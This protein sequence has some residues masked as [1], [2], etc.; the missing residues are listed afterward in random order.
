MKVRNKTKQYS[1][2]QLNSVVACWAREKMAV[3]LKPGRVAAIVSCSCHVV[4]SHYT[5]NWRDKSCI[6]FE[7]LLPRTT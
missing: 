1:T 3:R 2:V 5:K 7:D 6:V 4:V